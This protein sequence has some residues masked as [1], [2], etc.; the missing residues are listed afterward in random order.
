MRLIATYPYNWSLIADSFNSEIVVIPTEKRSAFDCWEKWY[1]KW[2]P[3]KGQQRPDQIPPNTSKSTAQAP[4]SA[5]PPSS[6]LT[7]VP[8]SA[9]TAP[10]PTA[11]P[12]RSGIQTPA[13]T[14]G[15]IAVPTLPPSSAGGDG[16]GEAPPPPGLSKREAR[17]QKNKYE[18]SKKA[19]RHQVLYD[20]MRRIS[21]RRDQSKQKAS[22]E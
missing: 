6:T 3:G 9:S 14:P 11:G 21:R 4:P 10:P 1:W 22:R 19:I 18:G 16:I 20:T 2:G 17:A 13:A 7:P 8:G 15:A 5:G 12:S